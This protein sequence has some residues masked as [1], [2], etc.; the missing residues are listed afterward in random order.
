MSVNVKQTGLMEYRV[1]LTERPPT[2]KPSELESFFYKSRIVVRM[3]LNPMFGHKNELIAFYFACFSNGLF[4]LVV[5]EYTQIIV[6]NC[7]D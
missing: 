2:P 7:R 6:H 3:L 1:I 4:C 5:S